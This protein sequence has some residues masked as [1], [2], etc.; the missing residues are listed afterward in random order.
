MGQAG[1]S[2]LLIVAQKRPAAR[3]PAANGR[4]AVDV[5][6]TSRQAAMMRDMA[7]RDCTVWR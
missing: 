5:A 7:L 3:N 6:A 1:V 2:D 4:L